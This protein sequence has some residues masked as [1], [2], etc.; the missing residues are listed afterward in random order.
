MGLTRGLFGKIS[1]SK[2][3]THLEWIIYNAKQTPAPGEHRVPRLF[4]N[5]KERWNPIK[6]VGST[7]KKNNLTKSAPTLR[8][9]DSVSNSDSSNE[10]D[11]KNES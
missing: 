10:K 6:L 9:I 11:Q 3:K 1:E 8:K 5:E 2:P 7:L 4:D